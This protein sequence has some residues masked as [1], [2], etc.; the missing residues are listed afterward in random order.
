MVVFKW[1]S[2]TQFSYDSETGRTRVLK[3]FTTPIGETAKNRQRG[4][5]QMDFKGSTG[6]GGITL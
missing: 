4:K 3:A 1:Q 6:E 2:I 5:K